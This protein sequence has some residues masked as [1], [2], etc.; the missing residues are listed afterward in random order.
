M[1]AKKKSGEHKKGARP[2]TREKHQKGQAAKKGAKENTRWKNYKSNGGK[3]SKS[4]WKAQ[5]MPSSLHPFGGM[6]G[7]R[8]LSVRENHGQR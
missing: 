2:S 7:L 3:L 5:G 8:E 6:M 4:A 1:A